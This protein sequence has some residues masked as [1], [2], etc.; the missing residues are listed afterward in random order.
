MMCRC[1][2]DKRRVILCRCVYTYSET[3]AATLRD[4]KHTWP[5]TASAKRWHRLLEHV[6]TG[7]P[8]DLAH[9]GPVCLVMRVGDRSGNTM[10]RRHFFVEKLATKLPW[11]SRLDTLSVGLSTSAGSRR[12][13]TTCAKLQP[14]GIRLSSACKPRRRSATRTNNTKGGDVA[15]EG[16]LF[17]HLELG[18][19][20]HLI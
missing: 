14:S 16:L 5:S 18:I 10:F 17:V 20:V 6:C 11:K 1:E 9:R 8:Q 13:C 15:L 4:T 2:A 12:A 3:S 7:T 19:R